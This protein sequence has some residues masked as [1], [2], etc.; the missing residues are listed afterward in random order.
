MQEVQIFTRGPLGMRA[1]WRF[2]YFRR[3]PEGLN[4]VARTEL[5]YFPTTFEP[6]SQRGQVFAM[7]VGVRL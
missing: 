5:E 4:L 7:N 2:G 3:S 6:F 1:H